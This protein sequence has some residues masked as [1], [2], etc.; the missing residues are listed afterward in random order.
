L[1]AFPF[2]RACQANDAKLAGSMHQV[3]IQI[4][5]Y[6]V[7]LQ[8]M[9]VS[10]YFQTAAETSIQYFAQGHFEFASAI[11]SKQ[12]IAK[13]LMMIFGQLQSFQL[14]ILQQMR[15]QN[16]VEGAAVGLRILRYSRIMLAIR[17]QRFVSLAALWRYH[18]SPQ[19]CVIM[20]SSV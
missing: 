14:Q 15:R 7:K 9:L 6:V 12:Q 1:A 11:M 17:K 5:R 20:W 19:A 4:E 18:I 10:A 13:T 8:C 16:D 3:K 2:L